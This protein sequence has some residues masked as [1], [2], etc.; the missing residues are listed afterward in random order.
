MHH[1]FE[2]ITNTAGDS[3]I[4]YFGR[5]INRTTQNTVTLSSDENGT[6]IVVVS[7]VENMAKT[8]DYG[9]L[10]L[11]VEPGTYHLDIYAPNTTT[12]LFRVSDV[13]MNSTKGDTGA[14]GAQGEVGESDAT[15]TTLAALKAINPTAYPSPRLSA[16]SGSDGGVVNGLFTYQTGNFTGRTDVVQVNGIALTT[17]AL[18]RQQAES[19]AYAK[20]TARQKFDENPSTK[21]QGATGDGTTNDT[22]N[23]QAVVG[24]AGATV[25][26]GVSRAVTVANGTHS[27]DF[28]GA[29]G[30]ALRGASR[31]GSVIKG[32]SG[33]SAA[34]VDVRYNRD[35]SGTNT[36]GHINVSDLTVNGNATGRDGVVAYGGS[37]IVKNLELQNCAAA[38]RVQYVLMTEVS[39][40]HAT[41]STVGVLV[42]VDAIH[43]G[44]VNTSLVMSAVWAQNNGTGFQ[45]RNLQYSTFISCCAQGNTGTGFDLDGSLGGTNS[46]DGI[47][48]ISCAS[49]V[50]LG[51]SFTFKALRSFS[52]INPLI[53]PT[54]SVNTVVVNNSIGEIVGLRDG[55]THTGGTYGL[56]ITSP[57]GL[58]FV[59][60]R[61]GDFTMA[62]TETIYC[63]FQAA[64]V[65]GELRDS[66]TNMYVNAPNSVE[67]VNLKYQAVPSDF[68]AT[69]FFNSSGQRLWG[70]RRS[71]GVFGS[72]G[73]PLVDAAA[74]L[75]ANECIAYWDET[76][77][78]IRLKTPSGVLKTVTIALT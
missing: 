69:S 42:D 66:V 39:Q 20:T 47:T 29:Q 56:K 6:P 34:I 8:D 18:V 31:K 17:G 19:L 75:G 40:V 67:M 35:G 72:N 7:G 14:P 36:Q 77:Y 74:A 3:L 68:S 62:P 52:L 38:L 30:T 15:F 43:S 46:M 55:I 1:F 70:V 4:G 11:Y 63:T 32:R 50:N 13:A 25:L 2:A 54:A 71:G 28:I 45:I 21:D 9:N 44:D 37:N 65:N 41:G 49:E 61:G 48:L 10:S 33:G 23:V 58:G 26:D 73:G 24:A 27:V 64:M 5:V 60:V 53:L 57:L 12:F 78:T 16:V 22:A 76:N 59:I 51:S